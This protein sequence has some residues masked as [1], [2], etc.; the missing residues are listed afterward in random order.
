MYKYKVLIFG[1]G[2]GRTPLSLKLN[3]DDNDSV[4]ALLVLGG[5]ETGVEWR[6]EGE[7]P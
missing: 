3:T 1:E 7:S 5:M 4:T 6:G 2:C